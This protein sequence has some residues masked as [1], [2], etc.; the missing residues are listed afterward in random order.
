MIPIIIKKDWIN[1]SKTILFLSVLVAAYSLSLR[2][3]HCHQKIRGATGARISPAMKF[4]KLLAKPF[5]ELLIF[6]KAQPFVNLSSQE[7]DPESNNKSEQNVDEAI[8]P[9]AKR[10]Y[11]KNIIN[12][13]VAQEV[14]KYCKPYR[15]QN[16]QIFNS[17]TFHSISFSNNYQFI[18]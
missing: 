11:I 3:T 7:V 18:T 17:S 4:K 5:I 2:N 13:F 16:H 6:L 9:I 12:K 10:I 1:L 15:T 14:N 8:Q